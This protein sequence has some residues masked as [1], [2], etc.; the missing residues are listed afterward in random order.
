MPASSPVAASRLSPS[1]RKAAACTGA[2]PWG[3][4]GVPSSDAQSLAENSRTGSEL[5]LDVVSSQSA[6]GPNRAL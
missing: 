5:S 6:A 2:V 1:G 4:D 3:K